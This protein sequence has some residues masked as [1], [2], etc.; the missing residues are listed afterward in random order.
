MA[1]RK[2]PI[3]VGVGDFKNRSQKV[4]DATEPVDLM[5]EAI[6]LAFA[7]SNIQDPS[8]LRSNT[9]SIE[10]VLPWTWPYPDLAGLLAQKL[11]VTAI[12][13]FV[14]RHGGNQP[15][16]LLDRAARRISFGKSKVVV[17]TGGEALASCMFLLVQFIRIVAN[18]GSEGLCCCE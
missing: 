5:L 8:K 6:Q 16:K 3:I 1:I 15:A 7:D 14:S 9:D 2:T 11:G 12:H 4:E 18:S 13:K 10:V 17:I